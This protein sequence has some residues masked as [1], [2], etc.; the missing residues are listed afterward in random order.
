MQHT[1]FLS[2]PPA[3][4]PGRDGFTESGEDRVL[5]IPPDLRRGGDDGGGEAPQVRLRLQ[6]QGG[7]L[8]RWAGLPATRVQVSLATTPG[9]AFHRTGDF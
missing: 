2:F 8:P 9:D 7:R 6:D 5:R 4:N 3:L 1:L